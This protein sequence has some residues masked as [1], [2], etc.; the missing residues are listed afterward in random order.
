MEW[1]YLHVR[2][3]FSIIS[4]FV[5]KLSD[6]LH[7]HDQELILVAPV[8]KCTTFQLNMFR[9]IDLKHNTIH[10]LLKILEIWHPMWIASPL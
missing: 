5:K 4:H 8:S 2:S 9:H 7:S 3:V 6:E 10:L 1:G